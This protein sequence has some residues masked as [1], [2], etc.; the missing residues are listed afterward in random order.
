MKKSGAIRERTSSTR[1][2][3]TSSS[4]G[5]EKEKEG[6]FKRGCE[7]KGPKNMPSPQK[8]PET[9]AKE[10]QHNRSKID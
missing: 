8:K 5:P 6:E 2:I 7:Q 3:T 1:C 10:N 9:K 4:Q